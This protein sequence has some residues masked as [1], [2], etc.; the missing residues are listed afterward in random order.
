MEECGEWAEKSG[1]WKEERVGEWRSRVGWGEERRC[2]GGARMEG[3]GARGEKRK[4]QDCEKWEEITSICDLPLH[5]SCWWLLEGI[6]FCAVLLVWTAWGHPSPWKSDRP[7]SWWCHSDV[8][9]MS[10]W[11]HD[12]QVVNNIAKL[13]KAWSHSS[14]KTLT[15][16]ST[17]VIHSAL[18][19]K[20][21]S[22]PEIG[23]WSHDTNNW[24]Q[25][26]LMAEGTPFTTTR[27][28]HSHLLLV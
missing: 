26:E 25:L 9:I 3:W 8:I 28:N 7:R 23:K 12:C 21:I 5:R 11:H 20:P 18:R 22:P 2:G 17:R 13:A 14:C 16:N 27:Y 6:P 15:T 10:Q 24:E 19:P 1:E 4:G